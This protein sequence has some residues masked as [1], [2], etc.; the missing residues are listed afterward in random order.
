M[1]FCSLMGLFLLL[2][3]GVCVY[4]G[5]LCSWGYGLFLFVVMMFVIVVF[6]SIDWCLGV[7]VGVGF[8]VFGVWFCVW[9]MVCGGNVGECF[10]VLCFVVMGLVYVSGFIF[11]LFS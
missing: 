8:F 4:C 9:W 10:V 2:V 1:V 7:I 11:D 6:V 5:L 3:V